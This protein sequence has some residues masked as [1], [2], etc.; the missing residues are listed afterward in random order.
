MDHTLFEGG[1]LFRNGWSENCIWQT[2]D[3]T[4]AIQAFLLVN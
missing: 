2:I 3:E 1:F 4:P